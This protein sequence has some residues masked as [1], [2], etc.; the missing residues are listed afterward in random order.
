MFDLEAFDHFALGSTKKLNVVDWRESG[1]PN[2]QGRFTRSRI[3]SKLISAFHF[4]EGYVA[5]HASGRLIRIAFPAVSCKGIARIVLDI[6]GSG[7]PGSEISCFERGN[8]FQVVPPSLNRLSVH[9][10]K[11]RRW[12]DVCLLAR[13]G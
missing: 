13:A 7:F 3:T 1:P 10:W 9:R 6:H 11:Y 5:E 8:V 12:L 2:A 4:G